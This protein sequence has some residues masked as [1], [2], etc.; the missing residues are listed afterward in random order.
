MEGTGFNPYIEVRAEKPR[1]SALRKLLTPAIKFPLS[2][3]QK[4]R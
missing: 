2:F 1:A 4:S 3:L